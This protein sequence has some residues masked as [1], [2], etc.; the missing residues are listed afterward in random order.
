M[1][2]LRRR[3]WGQPTR[4][5]TGGEIE[6]QGAMHLIKNKKVV[7][8]PQSDRKRSYKFAASQPVLTG[9]TWSPEDISLC[10]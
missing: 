4:G 7:G 9:D 2:G 8:D 5:S 3:G 1:Q 10:W 6:R